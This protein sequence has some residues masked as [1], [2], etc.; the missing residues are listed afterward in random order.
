MKAI[1][2]NKKY[3]TDR[4]ELLCEY[5]FSNPSDFNHIEEALYKT[6]KGAYFIAGSGGAM[7]DYGRKCDGNSRCGSSKIK[8]LN[9]EEAFEFCREHDTEATEKHFSD[10]IEE[11]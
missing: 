7:S 3:D 8:V 9:E 11:A 2:N 4:V 5:S 1:I 10:I 6:S